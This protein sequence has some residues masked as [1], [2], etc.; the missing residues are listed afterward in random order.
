MSK[1][2]VTGTNA[3]QASETANQKNLSFAGVLVSSLREMG[4]E[5]TWTS[6]SVLMT[7]D[8]LSSFDSI[9]VGV[10]PVTSLAS[11]RSYG[12][13]SLLAK[14]WGNKKLSLFTDVSNPKQI[15]V[16]LKQVINNPEKL[17]K[18]F[19]SYRKEYSI[20][21]S[22][23][24]YR[25]WCDRGLK[26]LLE[27]EWPETIYASLPWTK[28][29]QIGLAPNAK[30][31]L[32]RVNL[33]SFLLSEKE[34]SIEDR[35]QKWVFDRKSN[36]IEKTSNNLLLP[37][38]PMKL[39]KA[40]DDS[41]VYEQIKRSIGVLIS[42]DKREGTWW[43]YRYIQA[44]KSGTPVATDWTESGVLGEVWQLL[45]SSIES[46]SQQKRDLIAT[47][48]LE[49]YVSNIPTRKEMSSKITQILKIKEA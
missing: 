20:V 16:S 1:I 47:A 46:M 13:L 38:V 44:L 36:W 42:P 48:Q 37:I 28:V 40:W 34:T 11:D 23:L 31:N 3:P 24:E 6:P 12:V 30:K 19:Y 17:V 14:L 35:Q 22:S 15:E 27:E 32:E 43:S 9:L 26:V 33:D 29:E 49:S 25:Q 21:S 8:S 10:G 2:F 41:M 4:H 18:T 5:V 45:A 39:S 7:E